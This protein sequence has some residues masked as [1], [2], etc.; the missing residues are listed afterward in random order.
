MTLKFNSGARLKRYQ[1]QEIKQTSEQTAI[2]VAAGD[3]DASVGQSNTQESTQEQTV[4][5]ETTVEQ[6]STALA[7]DI[8]GDDDGRP[9]I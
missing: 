3:G 2:A 7:G 9:G 6:R 5:S 4:I 1:I 8:T